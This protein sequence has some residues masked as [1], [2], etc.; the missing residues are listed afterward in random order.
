RSTT[1]RRLPRGGGGACWHLVG[2]SRHDRPM[3]DDE[4]TALT[5]E[6]AYWRY[7]GAKEARIRDELGWSATRHA[8]VVQAL[9][10]RPDVEAEEPMVVRRLRRLRDQRRALRRAG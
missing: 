1:P 10:D 2:P 6:A 8:E 9:I 4:H 5:I 7:P 3:T